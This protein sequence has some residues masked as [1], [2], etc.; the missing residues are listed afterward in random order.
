MLNEFCY[1]ELMKSMTHHWRSFDENAFSSIGLSHHPLSG[2]Q[3]STRQ[4][5]DGKRK[6]GEEFL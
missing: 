4:L 1:K 5:H 3:H 6:V 2:K